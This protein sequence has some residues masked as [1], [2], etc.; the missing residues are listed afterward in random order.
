MIHQEEGWV[1]KIEDRRKVSL[2]LKAVRIIQN[3][4]DSMYGEAT[5]ILMQKQGFSIEPDD[6]EEAKKTTKERMVERHLNGRNTKEISGVISHLKKMN[7]EV[8]INNAA[9]AI[10]IPEGLK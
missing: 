1:V 4:V 3:I 2:R 9:M 10:Q 6:I 5:L 8:K 7:M